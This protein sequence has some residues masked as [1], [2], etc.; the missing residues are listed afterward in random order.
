MGFSGSAF[1]SVVVA[2][3]VLGYVSARCIISGSVRYLSCRSNASRSASCTPLVVVCGLLA[4]VVVA[5][6][7]VKVK[8]A[9]SPLTI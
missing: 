4:V 3:G 1:L 6:E 2:G 8:T 9:S 5:D 7:E